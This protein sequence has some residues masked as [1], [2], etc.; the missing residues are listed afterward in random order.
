MATNDELAAVDHKARLAGLGC[1]SVLVGGVSM[2]MVGA[3]LSL[4]VQRITRG[5]VCQDIPACDWYIYAAVGAV[6]GAVTLPMFVLNRVRQSAKDRD[7]AR[8]NS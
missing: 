4:A 6:L 7:A 8:P 1:F 5:P 2:A 3:L